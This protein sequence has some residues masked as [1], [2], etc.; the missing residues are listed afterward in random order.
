MNFFNAFSWINIRFLLD[1]LFVTLQ[2]ATL[3]IILSFIIGG[4]QNNRQSIIQGGHSDAQYASSLSALYLN[5]LGG[6]TYIG[7]GLSV[8]GSKHAIHITRDGM[9][10]TPA[11]EM[12][13]SYLGDMGEDVTGLDGSVD[14]MIDTLFF[15]T[16]NTD[17]TYHVFLQAHSNNKVWVEKRNAKSFV[18]KSDAPNV[19]FSWEMKAKRRGYEKDRLVRDDNFTY[20]DIQTMQE[21]TGA[22]EE[23]QILK[24]R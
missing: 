12:A 14:I 15:D 22:P 10:A 18:V 6:M 19:S 20:E 17:Y 8:S 23:P 4:T 9:R 5:K 24:G 3:S 11:Y 13:E 1:G 16:I 2:V 21:Y 7:S